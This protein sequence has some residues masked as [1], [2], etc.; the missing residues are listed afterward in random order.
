MSRSASLPYAIAVGLAFA[1][2][3]S[4]GAAA[5]NWPNRPVTMVIP[6]GAGSGIDVL[7]RLLAP[8]LSE[9][10]GQQVIVERCTNAIMRLQRTGS[11]TRPFLALNEQYATTR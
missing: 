10:L 6:F 7:G 4:A 8:P 11:L 9:I 3:G 5:Q 2:V 1:V